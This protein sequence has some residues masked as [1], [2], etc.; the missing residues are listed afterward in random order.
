MR[1]EKRFRHTL[2]AL[3]LASPVTF[4][5]Q[6]QP[7]PASAP[8]ARSIGVIDQVFAFH[9][10]MAF[11]NYRRLHSSL[12]YLSPMQYEQR[13]HEVQRKKAA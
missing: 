2:L 12:G 8:S 11:Y 5:T 13:W 4:A 6:L 1:I 10:A 3:A 7:L 9:D